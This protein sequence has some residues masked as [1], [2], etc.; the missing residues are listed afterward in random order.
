MPETTSTTRF[1]HSHPP[2][3]I[4]RWLSISAAVPQSSRR[5][6]CID[7]KRTC[8]FVSRDGSELRLRRGW[9]PAQL[10]RLSQ[11]EE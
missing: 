6:R 2:S 5:G 3:L 1:A 7:A 9:R 8:N 4:E 11:E 10:M